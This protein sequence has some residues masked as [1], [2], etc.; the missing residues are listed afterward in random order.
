MDNIVK[1]VTEKAG[2]S[3]ARAKLAVD[4]VVSFLKDKMPAGVGSQVESFVS[5][6]AGSIGDLAGGLKDKVGGMFGK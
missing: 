1:M 5:G 3:E 2:I 6:G 4:T